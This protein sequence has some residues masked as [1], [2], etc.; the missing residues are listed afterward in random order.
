MATEK[1]SDGA[2]GPVSMG[3]L[4][5][6]YLT[7]IWRF[8]LSLSGAPDLA[9]DL[10]QAT[11]LRALEKAHL[12]REDQNLKGWLLTICRSIWLNELRSKAIRKTGS[13]ENY[14][15]DHFAD[16]K[17][18]ADVNIL[19]R[20][21]FSKVLELPEAQRATVELVYVEQ[22]TYR[23]AAEILGVPLGTVMSR[24]HHARKALKTWEPELFAEKESKRK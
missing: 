16:K 24:L 3:E 15:P 19:A 20:E 17:P 10:L 13:L 22:F 14:T 8:A 1:K 21:V 23:E 5:V 11:C 4:L 7:V 6:P 12:Y 2:D 18:G 9:D